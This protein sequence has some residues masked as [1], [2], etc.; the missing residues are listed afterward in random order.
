MVVRSL[1]SGHSKALDDRNA[2]NVQ[3]CSFSN[4]FENIQV[5]QEEDDGHFLSIFF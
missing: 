5:K 1:S 4:I 2:Y 3:K